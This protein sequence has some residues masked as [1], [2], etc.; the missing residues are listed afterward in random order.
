M[1]AFIGQIMMFGGNFAPRNWELCNGQLL[2][3]SQYTQLFSILGNR[4][5]G[6]GMSN[7]ALPD[8]RGRVPLAAGTGTGLT[9][10]VEGQMG[11]LEN[12]SLSCS[13]VLI[14]KDAQEGGDTEVDSIKETY[15]SVMQPWLCVN[16][17]IC[18]DGEYPPRN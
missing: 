15:I 7:F 13:K 16:F 5:G 2:Q 9:T 17:I 14:N 1:D 11:G 10:K 18:T 8:L 4:F 12:S 3:V 6:D